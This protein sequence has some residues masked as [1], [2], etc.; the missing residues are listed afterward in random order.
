MHVL[1]SAT[2]YSTT[3]GS[4]TA[5]DTSFCISHQEEVRGKS[6]GGDEGTTE[7][8]RRELSVAYWMRNLGLGGSR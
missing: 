7:T 1:S 8:I 5:Q 6:A 3:Q 2:A 4:G